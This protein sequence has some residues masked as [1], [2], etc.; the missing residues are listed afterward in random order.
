MQEWIPEFE[1]AGLRI[2]ALT[3]DSPEQNLA[4]AEGLELSIPILSDPEGRILKKIQMWDSRWKIAAYGFYLLGP[5]L[6]VISHHRGFWDTSEEA[7]KFF[8]DKTREQRKKA[9]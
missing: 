2:V 5:D 4:V 7:R 6:E 9:S 8:L 1:Q 3:T